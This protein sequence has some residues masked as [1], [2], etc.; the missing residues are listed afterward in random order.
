MTVALFDTSALVK[1][2]KTNEK[3]SHLVAK[4]FNDNK[5]TKVII[6][7]TLLA[8][9]EMDIHLQQIPCK[10][11]IKIEMFLLYFC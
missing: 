10:I 7:I 2:Y 4:I 6:K 9:L 1:W 3:G 5:Y 11:Q 8:Q